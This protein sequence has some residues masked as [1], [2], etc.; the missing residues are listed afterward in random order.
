MKDDNKILVE[1]NHL[2]EIL[3]KLLGTSN[4][5]PTDQFSTE[6]LE[7][8]ALEF[9]K[10]T[11]ERGEWIDSDEISKYIKGAYWATGKFI[12][13]EFEFTNYFKNKGQIYYNKESII[14]LAKALKERNVNI[15]RY[16]TLCY[17]KEEFQKKIEATRLKEAEKAKK[18]PFTLP[19]TAKNI[20]TSDPPKPSVEVVR[21]DLKQLKDEF[22]EG[23]Y[24]EYIDIYHGNYAMFKDAYRYNRWIDKAVLSKLKK[25]RDSFNHVNS[26]LQE[27]TKKKE[28]FVPV[29]EKE[30]IR[31]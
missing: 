22:F 25:W 6:A 26:V 2:K 20:T 12:I 5:A 1:I 8:A 31:L 11:T 19:K 21:A 17:E 15:D 28:I 27:L 30:M 4:L 23:K 14:A 3:A 10:L 9:R 29:P 16:M 13:K 18:K 7:K 24:G